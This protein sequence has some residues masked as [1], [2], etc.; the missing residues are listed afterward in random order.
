MAKD[1][2][3]S[4]L[5]QVRAA[6]P[7]LSEDKLRTIASGIYRDLGGERHYIP[8]APAEG[9]AIRL[10]HEL[11]AGVPLAQAFANLGIPR[12]TGFRLLRRRLAR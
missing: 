9:K 7:E 11:A 2:V 3:R 1:T 8:K 6:A 4:I 5:D 12:R 10:G